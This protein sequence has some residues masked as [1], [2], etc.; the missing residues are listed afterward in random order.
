MFERAGGARL[1]GTSCTLLTWNDDGARGPCSS[2]L[3]R[4]RRRD[5][6]SRGCGCRP[7]TEGANGRARGRLTAGRRTR[8]AVSAP[9]APAARARLADVRLRPA[10]AAVGAG[11]ARRTP[12]GGGGRRVF[13][14][15]GALPGR[16]SI[17]SWEWSGV[18]EVAFVPGGCLIGSRVG[19]TR[20]TVTGPV[21]RDGHRPGA[22][23]FT[24]AMPEGPVCDAILASPARPAARMTLLG[25][26][27]IHAEGFLPRTAGAAVSTGRLPLSRP[28]PARHRR[29]G[30]GP[31]FPTARPAP[32]STCY[33]PPTAAE[34][35]APAASTPCRG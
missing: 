24:A 3:V 33:T 4:L 1:D 6:K 8:A 22:E 7:G 19:R 18:A 27:G 31:V 26:H 16:K 15:A 20:R 17:S 10:D 13:A 12:P 2:A 35:T 25:R 5:R 34:P 30:S 9:C 29:P 14:V 28:R 11:Y 23:L 32:A 21:Q